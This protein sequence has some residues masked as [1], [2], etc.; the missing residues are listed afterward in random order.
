MKSFRNPKYLERYEDVVFDLEQTININPR[1]NNEQKREGMR[2]VAD[3]AGEA[4]RFDW[5]N[6]RL[7][8]NLKVNKLS[9]NTLLNLSDHNGIVNGSTTLIKTLSITAN[10]SEVYD[11]DYAN[12]CVNI[13]NL[14]EY[15]PSYAKS[16]GTNEFYFPD[17]SRHADEIKY[18]RGQVEHRRNADDSANEKGEMLDDVNVNYNKGLAARK[19]SLGLSAELNCEIPLTDIHF[20][21]H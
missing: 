16:V 18:T 8:V 2:I 15:N 4:T 12:H 11:C 9:N 5:Y 10:G 1:N 7:S 17:T 14:L 3:N 21:N 20:L 19:A 13:E 6:S